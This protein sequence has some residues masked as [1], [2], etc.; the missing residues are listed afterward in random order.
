[1]GVGSGT[2]AAADP[3]PAHEPI[4]LRDNA[5]P[6]GGCDR[7]SNGHGRDEAMRLARRS[8][9]TNPMPGN[10]D[11]S[12]ATAV[13]AESSAFMLSINSVSGVQIRLARGLIEAA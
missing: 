4:D 6:G 13:T 12:G 5:G 10:S 11:R 1:M 2:G 9:M 8:Q 3:V 7:G